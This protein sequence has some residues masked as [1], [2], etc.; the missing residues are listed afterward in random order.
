MA[1]RKQ[2]VYVVTRREFDSGNKKGEFSLVEI[3][4]T[5]ESANAGADKAAGALEDDTA[6]S[7]VKD[8][9]K[10]FKNSTEK[11]TVQVKK[12]ELKG[13]AAANGGG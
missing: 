9:C 11:Y 1:P 5:V 2:Y 6:E 4:A 3:H 12:V 8:G 13:E 10:T 7:E